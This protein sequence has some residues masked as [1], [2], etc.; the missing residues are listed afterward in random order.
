MLA[1]KQAAGKCVIEMNTSSPAQ[2]RSAL[3][4][5]HKVKIQLQ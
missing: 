5:L 1:I 4:H 2:A 3:H